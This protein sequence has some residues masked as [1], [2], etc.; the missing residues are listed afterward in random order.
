MIL[1]PLRIY[2]LLTIKLMRVKYWHKYAV[3]TK[4][5]KELQE[6]SNKYCQDLEYSTGNWT[7]R[8][9]DI[10][11]DLDPEAGGYCP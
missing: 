11:P 2:P 5:G 4:A 6:S 9:V 10:A 8:V 7:L 1:L 3:L